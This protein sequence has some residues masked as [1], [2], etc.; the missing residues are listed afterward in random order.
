MSSLIRLSEAAA[1]ALHAACLLARS[2]SEPLSAA[3]LAN[4][5]QASEAHLAKVMQRLVREGLVHSARGPH[6][7]FVLGRRPE[8]L[9]LLEVCT[10]IEGP[11]SASGCLFGEPVCRDGCQFGGYLH[12][13]AQGL[14]N[15]LATTR[16][17]D[18][19]AAPQASATHQ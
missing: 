12:K 18:V 2:P 5:L 1:L 6:G 4:E 17:A 13:V 14:V 7:G 15:Y 9:T 11:I 19:I 3:H 8:D 10:A 16:L